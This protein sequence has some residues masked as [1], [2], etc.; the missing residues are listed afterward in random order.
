MCVW[1]RAFI[2]L[3]FVIFVFLNAVLFVFLFCGNC[4]VGVCLFLQTEKIGGEH[5]EGLG[6]GEAYDQRIFKVKI[7]LNSKI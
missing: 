2:W 7:V 1:E 5:L 6:R 4:V 3:E